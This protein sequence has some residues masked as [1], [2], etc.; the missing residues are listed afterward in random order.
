MATVRLYQQ[1][2]FAR[3]FSAT[4]VAHARHAD[5]PSLVLDQTG[6]Y[7]EAGGQMADHGE[8]TVDGVATAV[9]DVQV[10]D[11]GVI[12]HVLAGPLPTPG[13]VVAG[14]IA[15]PRRR[16]HMAL[17]TGQ[18]LLSRALIEAAGAPTVSAR[19]GERGCTIDVTRADVPERE[20]A[21]AEALANAIIDDDVPIRAWF[22]EPDELAVLP[23]RREPKVTAEIRVVAI[24]DF[25][26]SPCGGTHCASAAQIG[27]VR[28]LGSERYKGMTRVTFAAGG[29]ARALLAD[30][31]E[32]LGRIARALTCGPTDVP[33]AVD[34]LRRAL[35]DA[36]TEV[37]AVRER[38]AVALA[39]GLAPTPGPGEVITT[40][41]DAALLRPLAAALTAAG[42]DALVAAPGPDGT[43]VL[44]A[45]AD[46]SSLD[47]GALLKRLAAATGGR[48]GGKP[49]HAEGRLPAISDWP[50]T[51]AAAR[52]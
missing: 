2:A 51:V 15:W 16:V 41:D 47:C 48:G 28:V 8:V 21:A 36:R 44:L 24:G 7:P 25:D 12:H 3:Q 23:L 19:L 17:H 20:L 5:R 49:T 35:T 9:V 26:V 13:A 42:R 38:L 43:Q 32:A 52:A 27:G 31:S 39:A 18:H 29:R 33:A 46:G 1:D 40:V 6:F 11:D 45:R 50:A 34:K 10:D 22:P 37:A 30:H 14:A 4:V